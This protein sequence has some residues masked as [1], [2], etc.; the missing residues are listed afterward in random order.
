MFEGLKKNHEGHKLSDMVSIRRSPHLRSDNEEDG[1][2]YFVVSTRDIP[3]SGFI[4]RITKKL[5]V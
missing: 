2:P 1:I 3:E 4:K 5:H